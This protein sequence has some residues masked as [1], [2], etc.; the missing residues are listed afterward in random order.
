MMIRCSRSFARTIIGLLIAIFA[1]S[2]ITSV[3]V[4]GQVSERSSGSGSKQN[5]SQPDEFE[6]IRQDAL[7]RLKKLVAE[8]KEIVDVTARVRVLNRIAAALWDRDQ[9]QARALFQSA[10]DDC[11]L[12]PT[13]TEHSD[14]NSIPRYTCATLRS[15]IIMSVSNRDPRWAHSL[16]THLIQ[17]ASC[18]FGPRHW[19]FYYSD[20]ANLT[21]GVASALAR[22][23]TVTAASLGRR[24]LRDGI[25]SSF[26]NLLK[27]LKVSD[28]RRAHELTSEAITK[29][30]NDPV[31]GNELLTIGRYLF[32][33]DEDDD[34][35][36][37]GTQK[38]GNP[39]SEKKE[40]ALLAT[41]F[42]D[43]T[44]A[45]TSRFVDS[46]DRKGDTKGQVSQAF[47]EGASSNDNAASFFTALTKFLPSYE[48]YRPARLASVRNF[49]EA[50]GRWIDP[51]DRAFSLD[52]ND[53]GDI[54]PES[55]A[56]AAEAST[57][58][59]TRD[60]FYDMAARKTADSEGDYDK[61]LSI[62]ARISAPELRDETVED[63]WYAQ[64]NRAIN[65]GKFDEAYRLALKVP[66]SECRINSMLW[67]VS[68]GSRN[69]YKT[70]AIP[71]LNEIT[72]LLFQSHPTHSPEQALM[73]MEIARQ[74]LII[75]ADR[76]FTAMQNAINAVNAAA[77]KP[78]DE[79]AMWRFRKSVPLHDPL[80][81]YGSELDAFS[82]PPR[83][84]YLRSLQL[85][86]SFDDSSLS[87]IAQ[88]NVLQTVLSVESIRQ[89]VGR[90][91]T[92]GSH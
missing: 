85:A 86:R 69:A 19:Y 28:V 10:Y 46:L 41:R 37:D 6:R 63:I 50:L 60:N 27:E 11:R 72:A 48:R 49:I 89:G 16:S 32:D 30:A 31:T 22:K 55:L 8:A 34:D 12:I 90:G 53:E 66:K 74:Y 7:K 88:L 64:V 51:V 25:P 3:A 33:D 70:Q 43:A 14:S 35:D 80:S 76:G 13:F 57:D 68:R 45:A 44:L 87:I 40:K 17:D 82:Y 15:E 61:A 83:S 79:D 56:A 77:G 23:D 38:D 36:S 91:V 73:L 1:I 58:S 42:L 39:E 18:S 92:G 78:V 65:E 52:L 67:I 54:T 84:D 29:I 62:A 59:K 5:S 47:S 81:L 9:K 26:D 75:D 2:V 24:S 20:R 71:L 4:T 21:L